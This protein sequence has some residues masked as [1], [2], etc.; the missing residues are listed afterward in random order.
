MFLIYTRV[1]DKQILKTKN[2]IFLIFQ[3]ITFNYNLKLILI[4][5]F[6]KYQKLAKKLFC[7]QYFLI[8]Y[9]LASD[10]K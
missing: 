8:N 4:K 7:A 3:I 5:F 10:R 1:H 2:K 6:Q 9:S